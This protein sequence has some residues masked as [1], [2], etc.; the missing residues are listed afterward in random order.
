VVRDRSYRRIDDRRAR[1][2]G[3]EERDRSSVQQVR[4]LQVTGPKVGCFVNI[5][6]IAPHQPQAK[7]HLNG[8]YDDQSQY[9]QLGGPAAVACRGRQ[10]NGL[11]VASGRGAGIPFRSG[12]QELR[13]P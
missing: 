8:Q 10:G 9:R 7:D 12:R 2:P 1:E 4:D 13:L 11:I 3:L 5:G 6:G